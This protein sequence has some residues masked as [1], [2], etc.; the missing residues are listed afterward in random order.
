MIK[1]PSVKFFAKYRKFFNILSIIL[2]SVRI[3]CYFI[4]IDI[5][6]S[7]HSLQ[8]PI[9]FIWI[10]RIIAILFT[11]EYILR[12]KYAYSKKKY[13][14]RVMGIIDLLSILPF[15]L[16]FALPLEFLGKIRAL[17]IICLLK[18]YRYNRHFRSI[19]YEI[20]KVFPI[21]RTVFIINGV[22][23]IIFGSMMYEI[24]KTIQPDKFVHLLDGIWWA[25]VTT[26]TIGYGDLAPVTDFG[27]II[28]MILIFS[29]CGF[30]GLYLGIFGLAGTRAFKYLK[31]L[32]NK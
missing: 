17:R 20:R 18:L 4:E 26:T 29:G 12:I 1:L 32:E 9:I 7:Q 25:T 11:I 6:K 3:I 19:F 2:I 14:F 22:I 31:D 10:E 30:M 27:R 5:F 8:S 15:W 21:L 23:N 16:G 24:E 28:A 13:I